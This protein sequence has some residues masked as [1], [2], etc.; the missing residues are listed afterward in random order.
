MDH[1]GIEVGFER[2]EVDLLHILNSF[3]G[4][5]PASPNPTGSHVAQSLVDPRVFAEMHP[6]VDLLPQTLGVG[7]RLAVDESISKTLKAEFVHRE[8]FSTLREPQVKLSVYVHWCNNF[9]M[10]STLGFM[11]PVEFRLVILTLWKICSD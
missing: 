1:V 2:L 5:S 11:S 9:R 7:K 8:R 6:L 4:N 10:H 3:Q